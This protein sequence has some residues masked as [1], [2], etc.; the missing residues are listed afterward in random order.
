[1][2]FCGAWGIKFREKRVRHHYDTAITQGW[3]HRFY[4]WDFGASVQHEIV[5]RL[6][7]TVGYFRRIYGN[8]LVTDN[9]ALS[10]SDYTAFSIP[11]PADP[12]LPG[13][14]GTVLSG[15]YDANPAKFGLS[16]NLVTAASSDGTQT[17]HWNGVDFNVDAR[18]RNSLTIQGGFSTGRTV[19][20]NCEI[21]AQVPES[22]F[23]VTSFGVANASWT[24]AQNCH[25][26]TPFLTQFRGLGSYTIPKVDLRVSGTFQSKP[27]AQLAANYNVPNA[28]ATA[29]WAQSLGNGSGG[30]P[31]APA[32]SIA[33][34]Q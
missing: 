14:G 8:F 22:L 2:T 4:N 24:P 28:V 18:L 31:G 33:S 3:G 30:E 34:D 11:V 16:N 15:L 25:L 5:P 9:L 7:A 20:D 10:P 6:S 1:M 12:R 19:T 23:S 29:S 32:R 17:E 13:G 27:G 26:E 21:V